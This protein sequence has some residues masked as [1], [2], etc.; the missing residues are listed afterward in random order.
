MTLEKE[1]TL[2]LSAHD[3]KYDKG[4]SAGR[5]AGETDRIN[6]KQKY[7]TAMPLEK[8]DDYL[9]GWCYGYEVGYAP[10]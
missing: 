8:P 5:T 2:V 7:S 6:N 4:Y 1:R 3:E 9:E 10:E